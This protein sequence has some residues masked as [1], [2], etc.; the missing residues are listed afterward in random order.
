MFFKKIFK[1]VKVLIVVFILLYVWSIAFLP[2]KTPVHKPTKIDTSR[3][4]KNIFDVQAIDT[5]KQS[6]DLARLTL[7]NKAY[8]SFIDMEM[9]RIVEAG[10]THAAISTAYDEEFIPV[11]ER[12]VKSARSHGLSVWFRGNFSGWER[13]FEYDQIDEAEHKR[14]LTTFIKN[15]PDLFKNGD[16]FTPCHECENGGT[17]DPRVTGKVSQYQNFLISERDIALT[18]FKKINKNIEVHPSMNGEIAEEIMTSE[19]V[20]KVGG[21]V[22]VDHYTRTTDQFH[23][24]LIRYAS[25]LKSKIGIGEFGAPIPDMN[26]TMNETQ[27]ATF[28][29]GLMDVLYRENHIVSIVNYW[30]ILD[31]STALLNYDGSRR[32]A[33]YEV[34]NYFDAPTVYGRILD[35][36]DN[37]LYGATVQVASTTYKTTY[38]LSGQEDGSYQVFLP[39]PYRTIIVTKEGYN[40]VIVTLP[41]VLDPITERDIHLGKVVVPEPEDWKS[42]IKS[43]LF[44]K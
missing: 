39:S 8:D 15:H 31:G 4:R 18:E 10:G 20:K 26:G 32:Q 43:F 42:K 40:P 28:V 16:I 36:E 41:S 1:V 7:K 44:N 2:E 5:M 19:T 21:T 3:L 29:K 6:R 38:N 14:L 9:E 11:L 12:W 23:K 13:W 34:K 25:V 22:F 27:Q 17:G 37:V 35:A 24:D 33:Y 30:D